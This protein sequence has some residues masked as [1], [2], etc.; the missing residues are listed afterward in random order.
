MGARKLKRAFAT[1][2]A[3]ISIAALPLSSF[4]HSHHHS[5]SL[6]YAP[7]SEPFGKEFREWNA[8]W[9]QFVLSIPT[10]DDPLQD[11]NPLHDEKGDRCVVGQRGPVWFLVGVFNDTGTAVRK[12]CRVP[13][14]KAL[15]FPVLNFVNINTPGIPGCGTNGDE[16]CKNEK[17]KDLR[18]A[19]A[20]VVSDATD[21]SVEVD[22][23]SI[24]AIKDEFRVKSKVFE[25]TVPAKNLFGFLPAGTYS[26]AVDDGF[27][28]MLKP[29]SVG[30][31]SIRMRGSF[32]NGFSMD[33]TYELT[34]VPTSRK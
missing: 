30:A 33:V 16:V 26:P 31:H 6:V 21:L 24:D 7:D 14:G 28:V 34:V 11:V 17:A 1:S 22:N 12:D 32:P 19:I 8:E 5:E 29:L 13:Q 4:A 3:A 23:E 20:Q 15:F 25:I 18:E 9:W 10:A 27:Y 2:I